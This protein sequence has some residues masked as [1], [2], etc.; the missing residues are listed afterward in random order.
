MN[1]K[2]YQ[3]KASQTAIYPNFNRLI[4]DRLVEIDAI[5]INEVESNEYQKIENIAKNPYYPALGLA[6]EIGEFCNKLKKVMRDKNGEITEEFR[7]DSAKE[8]GDILWYVSALC[9]ELNIDL[10]DVAEKNIEKL[11]SRKDR[12]VLGGSGDNR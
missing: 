2:E 7:K 6:G 5:S 12:G 3:E 11:F 9:S 1:F 8:I 4:V 10:E